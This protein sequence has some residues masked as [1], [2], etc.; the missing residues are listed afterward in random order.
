MEAANETA[1]RMQ[2]AYMQFDWIGAMIMMVLTMTY[3]VVKEGLKLTLVEYVRDKLKA[4][5]SVLACGCCRSRRLKRRRT[6]GSAAAVTAACLCPDSAGRDF[7]SSKP[8]E[9]RWRYRSTAAVRD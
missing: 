6:S 7:Y 8:W 4:A 3:E 5:C 2:I 1:T 9:E